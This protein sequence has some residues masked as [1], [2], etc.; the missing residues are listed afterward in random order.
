MQLF[1]KNKESSEI[2]FYNTLGKKKEKFKAI[3]GRYVKMY[4]CGPTVY[5]YAHIGN[6]RAFVFAETARRVLEYAGY[7]VKQVMNI[8]DFGHLVGDGDLGEDK[9]TAGLK[10]EG[11]ALTLENMKLLGERYTQAFIEDLKH[12]NVELPFLFPRASEHVPDQIAFISTL[13]EKRYAYKISDGIYFDTGKFPH[14]GILGGTSDSKEYSRIGVNSEKKNPKDFTLWKFDVNLGW[15]SPWGKGFPGWH[16][17]CAAMST[18]YLGKTFD[19]HTGG[20]DLAPIHHNNEIAEAEAATGKPLAHY[21]IHGAFITIE[22]KRIGKS[23][24]NAIRLYQLEERGISALAYRYLLLTAHYRQPMNFAW[25]AAEAAQTALQRAQ[26]FF[27][28]LKGEGKINQEYRTQFKAAINDDLN[29]PEAIAV[30]WNLIKDEAVPAG[31]KRETLMDFDRVLGIGFA[32]LLYRRDAAEK[33]SVIS[34]SD[35]PANVKSLISERQAARASGNWERADELRRAV[36][37]EGFSVEDTPEGP[38]VRKAEG[39]AIV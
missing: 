39:D 7:E 26:R 14:Y 4:T 19:I 16:I 25:S 24:G 21:F 13:L 22:G 1:G 29:M 9:M 3:R 38:V 32:P 15:E 36:V 28:D 17:E 20:I 2:F 8:T 6:F 33:L 27:T 35:L 30:M 5:D 23:E 12:L 18:K 10:R 34:V 11:M 31:D 37:E